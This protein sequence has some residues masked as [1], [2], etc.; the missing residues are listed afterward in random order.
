[1]NNI[2]IKALKPFVVRDSETGQLTS[3]A[4][5][6]IVLVDETL[7]NQLIADGLASLYQDL[8]PY[9]TK[10][11]TANGTYNVAEYANATVNVG[12]LTVTYDVN[13]GTGTI[14]AVT[15]I[16]GNSIEINDGTGVTAPTNYQFI[17]WAT[18]ATATQADV[19]SPYT[20]T[21]NTTLYA[22]YEQ[23]QYT[24]TYD[25][26]GGTGEIAA[27]TVDVGESVSLSDGTG[28]TAPEGNEFAGWAT[29]ATATQADV[30][31]PYTP[32]ANTTLY[33]VYTP[34]ELCTVT[35]DLGEGTGDTPAKRVVPMNFVDLYEASDIT[36]PE[37]KVF[38][39]WATN[40]EDYMNTREDSPAFIVEDT[41][42]YAI[43]DDE[44]KTYTVTF[45]L[46]GGTGDTPAKTTNAGGTI[47]TYGA[48][49]I[50]PPAGLEF[51]AWTPPSGKNIEGG[52]SYTPMGDCKLNAMYRLI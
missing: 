50:T 10:S 13:G 41:T 51:V 12:T 21:T 49:D 45:D 30:T 18:E 23:T 32:T 2:S 42:L 17:G 9:G 46:D 26:N 52:A 34:I 1:M 3:F 7:G 15:V 20:P 40:P 19:T 47:T 24:V 35:F 5:G 28:L 16:A 48:S 44:A 14:P 37:G 4:C 31:S 6:E 8:V 25:A 29:E 39:G 11:I 36:P 33:A 22:V 38:I 43:Y 27:V